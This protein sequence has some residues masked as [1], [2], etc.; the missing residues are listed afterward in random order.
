MVVFVNTRYSCLCEPS[1]VH[2]FRPVWKPPF[3]SKLAPEDRCHLNGLAMADGEPAYVTAVSK[4]DVIDGWR[5]RRHEGGL[6]IDVRS[7]AI[8]T[9]GLSMPHSPRV[10]AGRLW[11]LNSGTGELGH[12]DAASGKFEPLTFCPGFARGLAFHGDYAF[13]GLSKPRYGRFEGLALDDRLK[14]KDAEAW[15]GIQV[16]SLATGDVVH[17]LRLDGALGELFDVAVLPGV[18]NAITIG[19]QSREAETFITFETPAWER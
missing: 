17:W 6:I 12:V 18:K 10:H 11:V 4:S 7:N 16:I 13:V 14:E 2:S 8:V 1:L 15:C 19:P 5:D 9:E 3:I